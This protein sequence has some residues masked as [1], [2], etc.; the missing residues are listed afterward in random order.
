MRRTAYGKCTG[1]QYVYSFLL[2][3]SYN[4]KKNCF[5]GIYESDLFIELKPNSEVGLSDFVFPGDHYHF[6][7]A[8]QAPWSFTTASLHAALITMKMLYTLQQAVAS[9]VPEHHKRSF[10]SHSSWHL[11]ALALIHAL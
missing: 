3:P 10:R 9:P 7:E 8:Q 2:G 6:T 1:V 4:K 11:S 5:I